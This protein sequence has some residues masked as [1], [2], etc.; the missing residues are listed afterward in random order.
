[1]ILAGIVLYNPDIDRLKENLSAILKQVD[2]IILIDNGSVNTEE[3]NHEILSEMR[4]ECFYNKNNIGIAAALKQIMDLAVSRKAEWVLTLDQDS[5][6]MPQLIENYKRYFS[7]PSIGAMTCSIEDRNLGHE[8]VA[9]GVEAVPT[10]ITSG[11]LIRTSAYL[12]TSGYDPFLF[13][14]KVDTDICFSLREQNYNILKINYTGLLHEVGHGRNV[15]F[16]GSTYQMY[17]HPY[18]RAY[19]IARNGIYL[20]KKHP[21]TYPFKTALS[22]AV[23][24]IILTGI[25][26]D[27]KLRKTLWGIRGIIDG[28]RGI[29]RVV[30]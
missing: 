18:W 9:D 23:K 26:E 14:D 27:D 29:S 19:Y 28:I 22:F 3:I 13:I 21:Q 17:N 16:L 20:S 24:K 15:R 10:C 30:Q 1:M 8:G 7:D 2:G 25:F 5:V 11:M 4:C 6:C 12:K